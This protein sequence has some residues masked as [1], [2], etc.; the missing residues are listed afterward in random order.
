MAISIREGAFTRPGAQEFGAGLAS[1]RRADAIRLLPACAT[2]S[3]GET[4]RYHCI[5]GE[6]TEHRRQKM[7]DCIRPTLAAMNGE[8]A[9]RTAVPDLPGPR[10]A[11]LVSRPS[12]ISGEVRGRGHPAG[13]PALRRAS[14]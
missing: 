8:V 12:H 14:A 9:W 6:T 3:N 2:R 5:I 7:A 1:R 10:D 11:C 13:N 4:P